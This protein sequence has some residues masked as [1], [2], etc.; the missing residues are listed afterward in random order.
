MPWESR[1]VSLTKKQE[2][3]LKKVAES[4]KSNDKEKVRA[5]I[6]L[7]VGQGLKNMEVAKRLNVHENTVVKW[8]GRWTG[9]NSEAKV[10][11][12]GEC[13]GRPRSVLTESTLSK[14]AAIV[15]SKPPK[16]AQRWTVRK[17]AKK[18]KIPVATTQRALMELGI[19]LVDTVAN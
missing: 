4:P 8:R 7:L 15:K 12:Y 19:N 17:V 6:I 9:D 2:S 18:A 10:E 1:P 13:T 11:D 16:P 14:I 5:L 3:S